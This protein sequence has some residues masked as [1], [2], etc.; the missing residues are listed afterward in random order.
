M[1]RVVQPELLD[2]LPPTDRRAIH[3][4]ADL[5]RL[6]FIMRHAAIIS[7]A[8][9]GRLR[10]GLRVPHIV[11]LGAG[12]GTLL[13]KLARG[14]SRFCSGAQATLVDLNPVATDK[15][16]Q[17][18]ASLNWKAR[19]VT[20]DAYTFLQQPAVDVDVI[21]TNLFLHHFKDEP[22]RRL[23]RA[24]AARTSLFI[25]CEPRRSNLALNACRLLPLIGCNS[26][27]RHDAVVSVQA[28]FEGNELSALWPGND[29]WELSEQPAGLFSHC[30]VAKRNA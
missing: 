3:S 26:V 16:I 24:I 6:N 21:I 14:W 22:L 1:H 27:T 28:G 9:R 4:R 11:E 13:L 30:F 15:T 8:C 23:L 18:F 25:A 2:D 5:R 12:D 19:T 29:N 20:S 17:R 7:R 10:L